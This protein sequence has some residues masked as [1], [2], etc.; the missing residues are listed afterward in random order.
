MRR[1][2]VLS[3]GVVASAFVGG[4]LLTDFEGTSDYVQA[5]TSEG[6]PRSTPRLDDH[7][8]GDFELSL[9]PRTKVIDRVDE[10]GNY[11]FASYGESGP[12]TLCV[13]VTDLPGLGEG[14]VCGTR[15]R[16]GRALHGFSMNVAT[17]EYRI[18]G[19]TLPDATSWRAS[20]D[21][22]SSIEGETTA[23]PAFPH[24]R[25]F[26]I[27]LG[28][29]EFLDQVELLTSDAQ[30]VY[31]ASEGELPSRGALGRVRTRD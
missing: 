11:L 2:L 22:G 7:L 25:F 15:D 27:A 8:L 5:A 13:G 24:L 21:D 10:R 28:A 20:L 14:S 12:E 31:T 26:A 19:A 30:Q 23:H 4:V 29:D 18:I 1:S 16:V 17:G 9:I 3:L 6:T